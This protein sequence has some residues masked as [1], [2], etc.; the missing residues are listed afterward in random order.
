MQISKNHAEII[1]KIIAITSAVL[2][3]KNTARIIAEIIA[4]N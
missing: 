1:V 2:F 3:A 4:I